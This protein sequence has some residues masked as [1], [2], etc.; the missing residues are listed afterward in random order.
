MDI[1][2]YRAWF[3][4]EDVLRNEQDQFF[5][6]DYTGDMVVYNYLIQISNAN[7]MFNYRIPA[8]FEDNEMFD[9]EHES[10]MMIIQSATQ[11]I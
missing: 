5:W 3:S 8:L 4:T 6:P 10:K 9:Q 1:N 2:G 7:L 11:Y